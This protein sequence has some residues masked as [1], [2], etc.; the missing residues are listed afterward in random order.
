ML[1]LPLGDVDAER[2][3]FDMGLDSLMA[4]DLR[5]RLEAGVGRS[6][7]ST[8]AFNYPTAV[9]LAAFLDTDEWNARGPGA[10]DAG[11]RERVGG[12]HRRS[13]R[14]RAGGAARAQARASPMS[15][16]IPTGGQLL[17]EAL[18]AVDEMQAK[19]DAAERG[20]T[21]RSPSSE[22]AC[23]FP[24]GVTGPEDYWRLLHDGVD[25]VREVPADRWDREAVSPVRAWPAR[26]LPTFYGGFLDGID[27]FDPRF[28]GISPREAASMDPQQR[29][30]LEV[31]WE[32]LEHAGQAPGPPGRQPHRRVR[33]HHDERLRASWQRGRRSGGPRRLLRHRQRAQ[34]RRRARCPTCSACRGR[35]WRSTPRA[36]RRWWRCTWRVRACGSASATWRWPAASTCMLLPEPFDRASR[37]GRMMAPDGRCKTF[38][39]ARRRLR[40]RRG[41]RHGGAQAP[42][43]RASPTATASWR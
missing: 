37:S 11:R 41:L 27:R 30:L 25:A 28:F 10:T 1:R 43:R 14:G 4:L 42:V 16:P 8:L 12:R 18:R 33:R 22:W 31:S 5:S 35:A 21:S 39:A 3:L 38:D 17:R 34:R 9:A 26:G 7:P 19:L 23:R 24:G 20:E 6:L 13:V 2:G 36:R 40:A 15:T 32:A 29:L